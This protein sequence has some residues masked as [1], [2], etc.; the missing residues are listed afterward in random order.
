[1][2]ISSML[3]QWYLANKRDLP[4]RLF[5]DPYAIWL[6]EVIMQQTRV[7][8]G[9]PYWERFM[10]QYPDVHALAAASEDE[11]LKNWEGLGY[12]SRARNLHKTA[13]MVSTEL[14]GV[15]PK[16]YSNLLKLPGV[17][18]YIA[19][20]IASIC[21]GES[22]PV[23]DGNVYRLLSR[24][25]LI[26][27]PIN[28]SKA[29]KEF[30]SKAAEL[31]HDQVPSEINQAMMEYG[32]TVC[33]YRSP[34]C[35][36]CVLQRH[37]HAFS[38]GVVENLPIKKQKKKVRHREMN[39][40]FIQHHGDTFIKQRGKGDVWQGLFEFLLVEAPLS[41][42]PLL[43]GSSDR[44]VAV[45]D[46]VHIL[47]HQ[48]INARFFV[49]ESADISHIDKMGEG[50]KRVSIDSLPDFA[51]ARITTRFLEKYVERHVSK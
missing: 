14:N 4:W 45:E 35:V 50:V 19:A 2:E 51:F 15:F 11:V 49:I 7:E 13:K 34:S 3:T 27:T 31:L 36:D 40:H 47:S 9:T 25:Y 23:V 24:L 42:E 10:S 44:L 5:T 30:S 38:L 43:V 32:A 28:T 16:S 21:F 39:F 12:Y 37:C 48:R 26:E 18:P 22:V 33:T 46:A 6:S 17:G 8:Q 29:F 20:A 1:M 41:E